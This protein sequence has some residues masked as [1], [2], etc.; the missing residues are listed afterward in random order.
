M[1]YLKKYES[2]DQPE[3]TGKDS[4]WGKEIDGELQI[5]TLTDILNYLD[6]GIL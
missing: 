4:Y 5:I 6:K 3:G 1:K 2:F